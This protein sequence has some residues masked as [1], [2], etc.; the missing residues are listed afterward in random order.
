[1]KGKEEVDGDS[2]DGSGDDGSGSDESSSESDGGDGAASVDI[3]FPKDNAADL[4]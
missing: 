2:D 3:K 1:M 4:L